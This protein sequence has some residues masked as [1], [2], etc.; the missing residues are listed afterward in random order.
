MPRWFVVIR[1]E[2]RLLAR[3]F[4]WFSSHLPWFRDSFSFSMSRKRLPEKIQSDDTERRVVSELQ[5]VR[6]MV[7]FRFH[8]AR[9]L[10]SNLFVS[11]S[12]KRSSRLSPELIEKS[13]VSR[14]TFFLGKLF[15]LTFFLGFR[16][17][18]RMVACGDVLDTC[19]L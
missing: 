17:A 5:R 8:R 12:L 6:N 9:C 15:R 16:F 11:F 10:G 14:W 1:Y 13:N 3:S 7:S 4:N 2:A 19:E 18:Q